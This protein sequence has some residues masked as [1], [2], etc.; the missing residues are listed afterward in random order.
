MYKI[1]AYNVCARI[2]YFAKFEDFKN[3]LREFSFIRS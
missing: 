2:Q 3:Y 1:S